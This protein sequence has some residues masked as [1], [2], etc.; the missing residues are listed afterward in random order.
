MAVLHLYFVCGR[1]GTVVNFCSC[2]WF[3]ELGNGNSTPADFP[4][5]IWG[6]LVCGYTWKLAT[7]WMCLCTGAAECY[8]YEYSLCNHSLS[9]SVIFFV[10]WGKSDDQLNH[11][12]FHTPVCRC[13]CVC[14]DCTCYWSYYAALPRRPHY[15]CPSVCPS[16]CLFHASY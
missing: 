14:I 2:F 10:V 15:S 11:K 13:L 16:V 7:K 3:F 8:P 6:R 5:E 4:G 9:V 12:V 1:W